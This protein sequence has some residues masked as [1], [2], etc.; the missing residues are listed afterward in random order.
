MTLATRVCSFLMIA[1]FLLTPAGAVEAPMSSIHEIPLTV[2]STV[3]VAV[4]EMVK[5]GA[6]E[7][8]VTVKY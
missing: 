5:S 7:Q 3:A 1:P 6:P 4:K 2:E 8:S